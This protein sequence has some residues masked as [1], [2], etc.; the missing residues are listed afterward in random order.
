MRKIVVRMNVRMK[1]R[2]NVAVRMRRLTRMGRRKRV[3]IVMRAGWTERIKS[4]TVVRGVRSNPRLP[5]VR[6]FL[7]NV[8][9]PEM[10]WG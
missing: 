7:P 2:M 3:V 5:N 6:P 4:S 8:R 9:P 10:E 1:V